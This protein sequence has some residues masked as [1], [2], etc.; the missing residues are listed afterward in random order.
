MPS[1]M[2]KASYLNNQFIIAMPALTDPIFFHTVTYLCQHN[3]EG[4]LGIVINRSAEMKLGEIFKQMDIP[5]TSLE[6]TEA[7]VFAGGPVQQERGFVLHTSGGDWNATMPVSESI[8][9]TTSRDVLEAIAVGKGPEQYLV[10]LGYAGWGEGQ[11]EKEI[12]DNSWLN[13]P[14]G[15]QVL[16][17]TPINQRWSAAAGQIGID[18]N[19]LTT[20]AGHG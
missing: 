20:P 12:L 11:L 19:K 17:D 15:K 3:K 8:S 5:V 18:I 7:P 10:A 2:N 13:T 9:L 6:A 4:A 14:Y 1:P 16:F